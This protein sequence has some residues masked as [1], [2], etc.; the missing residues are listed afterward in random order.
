MTSA[1]ADQPAA[2]DPAVD[3]ADAAGDSAANLNW[4][5]EEEVHD[6]TDPHTSDVSD[7]VDFAAIRD[8]YLNDQS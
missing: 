8:D 5:N 6:G 4:T 1:A 3:E 7:D 2:T